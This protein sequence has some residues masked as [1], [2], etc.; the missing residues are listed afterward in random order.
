VKRVLHIIL[1]SFV[2]TNLCN[3]DEHQPPSLLSFYYCVGLFAH[4]YGSTIRTSSWKVHK[5]PTMGKLLPQKLLLLC[6][7]C[8][9]P[10]CSCTSGHPL[11]LDLWFHLISFHRMI[12]LAWFRCFHSFKLSMLHLTDNA[13][14][15]TYS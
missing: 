1:Y 5:I 6:W 15:S 13:V 8:C 11:C 4:D 2:F 14:L 7:W 9:C 12:K 3:G 10:T